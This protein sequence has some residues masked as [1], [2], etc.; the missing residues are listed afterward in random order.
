MTIRCKQD[1]S[2]DAGFYQ[3]VRGEAIVKYDKEGWMV[4]VEDF[5]PADYPD[6]FMCCVCDGEAT[7]E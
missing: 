4:D 3:Q 5:D 2:H 6:Y 1:E 7:D